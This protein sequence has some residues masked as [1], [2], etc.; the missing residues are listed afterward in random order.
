[1]RIRCITFNI[2]GL[3]DSWFEDRAQAVTAALR[4][5]NPDLVC[6]QEA[7]IRQDQPLYHQARAIG[8][9]LG[10]E[11]TVF[12]PYGN[13]AEMISRDQG[14]IALISRWPVCDV[15]VRRLP[16]GHGGPSDARVVVFAAIQSP[17]G[18]LGV[19]T[20]HLS[21]RPEESEVRLMQMGV[22][23]GEISRNPWGPTVDKMV[24]MGDLNANPDEPVIHALSET[25]TDAYPNRNPG[26]AGYTW[27]SH[28]PGTRT[29]NL[30]DRRIDYIFCDRNAIVRECEVIL[31]QAKPVFPSDHFGVLAELEWQDRQD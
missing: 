11:N 15:R 28:N 4:R 17:N 13:P 10:L 29:E 5:H 26:E 9:D 30:P 12:A 21:W 23:L 6:F 3:T 19:V 22:I 18:R 2:K 1:M 7:A 31:K 20:T 16:P 25:L 24:L 14:G 27:S 8:E